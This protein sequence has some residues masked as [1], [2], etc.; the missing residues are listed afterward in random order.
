[1]HTRNCAR[2]LSDRPKRHSSPVAGLLVLSALFHLCA[3]IIWPTTTELPTVGLRQ[4][5]LEIQR[6]DPPGAQAVQQVKRSPARSHT[7][8]TNPADYRILALT[9]TSAQAALNI[10]CM[11]SP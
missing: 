11:E 8:D 10:K 5:T 4:L 7:G 6:P 9:K 1:M 3:F 2:A